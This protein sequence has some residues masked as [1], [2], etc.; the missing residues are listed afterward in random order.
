VG[1]EETLEW[2]I[3]YDA[4][5]AAHLERTPS[6]VWPGL[7]FAIPMSEDEWRGFP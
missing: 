6:R 2:V 7:R 3:D 5:I 4:I 1:T